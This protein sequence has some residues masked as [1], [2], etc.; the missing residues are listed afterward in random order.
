MG[1]IWWAIAVPIIDLLLLSRVG[2]AIGPGNVL[3]W[4]VAAGL[5]GFA[6]IKTRGFS[7]RR[8]RPPLG[9][10]ERSLTFL[11][12]ILLIFPGLVSDLL[13]LLLLVPPVR[14]RL[15]TRIQSTIFGRRFGPRPGW[16]ATA[17]PDPRGGPR[18]GK[19][20]RSQGEFPGVDRAR[21]VEFEERPQEDDGSTPGGGNRRG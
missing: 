6:A 4:L 17:D 19:T 15:M 11:A 13:G 21:D 12:G 7:W 16:S 14:R 3:L 18:E 20:G 1:C 8:G 2:K 10:L 9:P 5:L